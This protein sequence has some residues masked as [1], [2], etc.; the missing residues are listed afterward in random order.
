[1]ER[2][3]LPHD[4]SHLGVTFGVPNTITIAMVRSAQTVHLSSAKTNTSLYMEPNKLPHDRSHLGVTFSVPNTITTAMVRSVQ[5]MHQSCA[6]T[7]TSL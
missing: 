5:I 4:R 7:N 3:K 1:M 2:N 6:K